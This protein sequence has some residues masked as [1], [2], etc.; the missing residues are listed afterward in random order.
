MGFVALGVVVA[1][2]LLHALLR[3]PVVA[4]I[5]QHRNAYVSYFTRR[6][7]G[8]RGWLQEAIDAQARGP[9]RYHFADSFGTGLD[10]RIPVLLVSPAAE[11]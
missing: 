10:R 11:R 9:I 2:W 6:L 8:P 5:E 7:N 1:G 4:T 3:G